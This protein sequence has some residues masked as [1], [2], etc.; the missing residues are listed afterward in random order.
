MRDIVR[1]GVRNLIPYPP[2]KPIEELERE[3]GV[4]NSI[5]LAS[6]ENPLG[7]SPKAIKAIQEK[8]PNLHRYPDGSAYYLRAKLSDIFGVPFDRIIIGNGS[9]ELIELLIRT[10]LSEGDAA[11]QIFPT[12]LMYEKI[13]TGAG[14]RMVSVP[15]KGWKADP[16]RIVEAVTPDVRFVFINNPNNPTGT[17]LNR[18]ETSHLLSRIPEDVIVILDEA[19][20]EFVTDPSVVDG[21]ELMDI[22]PRLCVLRTFSK[23]YGLAG[24]RIGYGFG[25]P[26]LIDFMH[27]V[28][29]PFNANAL[30]Q[31][32]ALA[33]LDDEEFRKR[34]LA[35]VA[36][37]LAFLHK[38]L[39]SLGL[40][41]VPTQTNFF[42]IRIPGGGKSLYES[43]LKEGVI[44]RAMDSYGLKDYIRISVGTEQENRRFIDTLK[45]FI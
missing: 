27:R 23:L 12:F 29:Q 21:T 43:M 22:H 11:V 33:A 10:F 42:L 2:G 28:R 6:N 25:A 41:Y 34:T 30:A 26:G 45:K 40:E 8:I 24:L 35:V 4:R 9:N 14:G 13:V 7:P 5:K 3:L 32:A 19:Y 38:S 18:E 20:I 31:A 15:L 36:E 1:E 39:D 37:G 44:I 16:E 17:A